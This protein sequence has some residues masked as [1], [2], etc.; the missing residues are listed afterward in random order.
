MHDHLDATTISSETS[1]TFSALRAKINIKSYSPI[2][3]GCLYHPPNV[4]QSKTQHYLSTTLLKLHNKYQTPRFLINGHFNKL[5]VEDL[6][7]QFN[8]HD[9][10]TGSLLEKTTN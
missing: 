1:S 10:V 4:E 3:V 2:I 5:P 7:E 8:L 9:L 6:L